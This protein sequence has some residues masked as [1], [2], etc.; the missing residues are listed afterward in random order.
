MAPPSM[1]ASL[2][3]E[4]VKFPFVPSAAET[5]KTHLTQESHNL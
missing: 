1:H 2:S 3:I 4:I 5:Q